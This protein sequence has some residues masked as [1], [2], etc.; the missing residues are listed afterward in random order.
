[1]SARVKILLS[2]LLLSPTISKADFAFNENCIRAYQSIINLRLQ[3]GQ[4]LINIEKKANPKNSIPILLENYI[5]FFK[6]LTTETESSFAKFKEL[7][8]SRIDKLEDDAQKNSPWYLYSIAEINLQSC[9]NRFKYQEFVTGAYELQKAY[10]LL[11][12][13]KKKFPNF[14]PNQKASLCCMAW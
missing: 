1:M 7:K 8:S 2:I 5:D 4:S 6:V 9:I 10:K 13:N 3:E 14:L 12:E 11:E